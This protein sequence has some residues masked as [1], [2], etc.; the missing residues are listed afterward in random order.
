MAGAIERSS[1]VLGLSPPV[2]V[3]QPDERHKKQSVM[4]SPLYISDCFHGQTKLPVVSCFTEDSVQHAEAQLQ[5]PL[6]S[7]GSES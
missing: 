4:S 7:L 2:T 1:T 5:Q 3:S 6:F